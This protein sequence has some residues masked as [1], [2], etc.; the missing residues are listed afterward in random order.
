M[1]ADLLKT[2]IAKVNAEIATPWDFNAVC[3][4]PRLLT[5]IKDCCR[6]HQRHDLAREIQAA[7]DANDLTP[8]HRSY[9]NQK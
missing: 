5:A 7:L 3:Q 9:H 8:A 2:A 1:N 6:F 4:S